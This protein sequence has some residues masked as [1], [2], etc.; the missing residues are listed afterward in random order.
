M[1]TAAPS[2]R[3]QSGRAEQDQGYTVSDRGAGQWM[4]SPPLPPVLT[5]FWQP[6]AAVCTLLI[7]CSELPGLI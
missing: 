6:G 5:V 7:P 1:N 2:R 3:T 4:C